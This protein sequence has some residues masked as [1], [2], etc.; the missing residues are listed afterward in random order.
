MMKVIMMDSLAT[1][2]AV[3][4]AK[5]HHRDLSS[6]EPT[7]HHTKTIYLWHY[8]WTRRFLKRKAISTT[9]RLGSL[10]RWKVQQWNPQWYSFLRSGTREPQPKRN[11]SRTLRRFLNGY[12][13]HSGSTQ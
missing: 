3:D 7:L 8:L 13:T 4:K 1:P 5:E 12:K 2:S 6:H 10:V 9:G 11:G